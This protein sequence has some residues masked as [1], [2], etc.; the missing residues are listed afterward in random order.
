MMTPHLFSTLVTEKVDASSSPRTF[1]VSESV[2]LI[3]HTLFL[4]RQLIYYRN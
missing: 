1:S 2:V 4:I 3:F